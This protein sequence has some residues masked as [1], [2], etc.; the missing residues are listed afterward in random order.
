[1]EHA[2]LA[3]QVIKSYFLTDPQLK[4]LRHN[5]NITYKVTDGTDQKSYLLRIHTPASEGFAGVQ[6]TLQGIQS[7]MILLRELN[8][9]KSLCVQK[10]IANSCGEY[11]T[12]YYT[13]ECDTPYFAT[14]LSWIEGATLTLKEENGSEIA[15]AIGETLATFHE[16]SRRRMPIQ[17][18]IRPMYDAERIDVAI[19]ELQVGVEL[20]LYSRGQYQTIQEVLEL[21]KGQLRELDKQENSWG[22]IH[23]DLQLG[24]IIM[25]ESRPCLIDFSLSGYGYDL[26]DVG[27]ASSML[28]SDLRGAFL[29]GYSA[30]RAFTLNDLRYVEGLI[31][32]DIFISYV[33]F[34]RDS[35]R[36][37]WIK[38]NAAE[39]CDTLCMD[40]LEGKSVYYCF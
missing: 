32:M 31:F 38:K 33:F 20:N 3:K 9:N 21:V 18:L 27:S 24:N 17:N 23:A 12:I 16:T 10:P 19:S 15:F 4:F 30:K 5:E 22:L 1:M 2:V 29:N 35:N 14:L 34:I 8:N 36:N 40:F 37:S 13:H 39:I 7:E 28:P 25:H 11:V 26:F 6:N